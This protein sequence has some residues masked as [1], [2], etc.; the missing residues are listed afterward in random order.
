M[1]KDTDSAITSTDEIEGL[2]VDDFEIE[3]SLPLK[4]DLIFDRILIW[5]GTAFFSLLLIVV[6]FQVIVRELGLPITVAWTEP[7]A[8]FLFITGTYFGVAVASRNHEHIQLTLLQDFLEDDSVIVRILDV[9]IPFTVAAI[10][11]VALYGGTVAMID[12]WGTGAMGGIF[13]QGWVYLGIVVGLLVTIIYE[14]MNGIQAISD[15]WYSL[16]KFKPS[17]LDNQRG[18]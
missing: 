18:G 8:R 13:R 1:A 10:L 9:V 11:A 14:I 16:E 6:I 15:N 7:L 4:Q 17:E 3:Q 2:E 5:I 12:N